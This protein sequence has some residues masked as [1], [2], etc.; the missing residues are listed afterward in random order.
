[1]MPKHDLGERQ[2]PDFFEK[3]PNRK[4][5]FKDSG[6]GYV[7]VRIKSCKHFT[8]IFVISLITLIIVRL[9]P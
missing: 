3:C 5:S 2:D 8:L 6:L 4:R 7:H 9:R 1:M